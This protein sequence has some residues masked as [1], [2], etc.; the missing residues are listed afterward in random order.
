MKDDPLKILIWFAVTAIIIT[1][2]E[3]SPFLSGVL[4]IIWV[5]IVI[6]LF[7]VWIFLILWKI[8]KWLE[9]DEAETKAYLE[10]QRIKREIKEVRKTPEEKARE[11]EEDKRRTKI[12]LAIIWILVLVLVWLFLYVRLKF[13]AE[14]VFG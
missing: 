2:I 5:I 9:E 4:K 1:T 3:K 12:W 8:G 6:I 7:L 11:I 13:W 10:K 14:K